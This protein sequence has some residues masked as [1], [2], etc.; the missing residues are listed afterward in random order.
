VSIHVRFSFVSFDILYV[1]CDIFIARFVVGHRKPKVVEL[2]KVAQSYGPVV[3]V[4]CLYVPDVL[5]DY[6]CEEP[7]AGNTYKKPSS[8]D[9]HLGRAQRYEKRMN[10]A[11]TR[12]N[13]VGLGRIEQSQSVTRRA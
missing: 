8:R 11:T 1:C 5:G 13:M 12:P 3:G 4:F 2:V 6:R 7:G 10:R 9:T